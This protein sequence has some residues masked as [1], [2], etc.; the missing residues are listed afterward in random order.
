MK[1]EFKRIRWHDGQVLP[2]WAQKFFD[3]ATEEDRKYFD[4]GIVHE[5]SPLEDGQ[6]VEWAT[7]EQVVASI[8][9]YNEQF[10]PEGFND[11]PAYVAYSLIKCVEAGLAEVRVVA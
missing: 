6:I 1:I 7:V 3:G 8:V 2:D 11:N 9:E 4:V 10:E 5:L